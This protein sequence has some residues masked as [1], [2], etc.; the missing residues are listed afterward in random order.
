MNLQ[1]G[2]EIMNTRNKLRLLE[3]EYRDACND[4][5]EDPHVR[6]ITLHSLKQLI[7]QLKEEIALS[8]IRQ[9]AGR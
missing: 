4:Q 3:E 7:N 9:P 2:Q 1:N 6:E 8:E 5:S